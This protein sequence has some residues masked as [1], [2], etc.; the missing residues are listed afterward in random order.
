MQNNVN[1]TGA[2]QGPATSESNNLLIGRPTSGL[3]LVKDNGSSTSKDVHFME[4][5]FL[6]RS[7][8]LRTAA[9]TKASIEMLALKRGNAMQRYKEKKKTRRFVKTHL[10]LL[11]FLPGL[12]QLVFIAECF[13]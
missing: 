5:S 8:S 9:T 6:V 3:A 2:S 1:N 12:L 11:L 7:D 10:I 13:L 4:E